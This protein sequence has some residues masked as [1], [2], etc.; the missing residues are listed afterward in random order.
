MDGRY[1]YAAPTERAPIKQPLQDE[2]IGL[3]D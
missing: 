1:I 3:Y 2:Q